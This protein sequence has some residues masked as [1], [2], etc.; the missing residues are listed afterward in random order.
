MYIF[1]DGFRISGFE[2]FYVDGFRFLRKLKSIFEFYRLGETV[3]QYTKVN[4]K[5]LNN[6]LFHLQTYEISSS[7][8][9]WTS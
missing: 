4:T 1:V 3:R 2:T 6:L 5:I 9:R 8:L 7:L